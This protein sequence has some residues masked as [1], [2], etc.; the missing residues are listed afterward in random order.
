MEFFTD[1]FYSFLIAGLSYQQAGRV[2]HALEHNKNKRYHTQRNAKGISYVFKKIVQ[3]L[4]IKL[5][6][7]GPTPFMQYHRPLHVI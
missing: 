5:F 6:K 3:L 2:A 4:L 7:I 1:V